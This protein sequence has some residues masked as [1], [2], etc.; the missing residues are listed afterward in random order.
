MICN[1]IS[2]SHANYKVMEDF[3]KIMVCAKDETPKECIIGD[4]WFTSLSTIGANLFTR[5]LKNINCVHKIVR[6]LCQ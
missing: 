2:K 6:I 3:G 1:G 4:T 5:H